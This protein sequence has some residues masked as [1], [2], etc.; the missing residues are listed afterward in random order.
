MSQNLP[1]KY[2]TPGLPEVVDH[3]GAADPQ[4]SPLRKIRRLL[5]GRWWLAIV[6]A[7]G[8]G[9]GL[10][11]AGYRYVTPTYQSVGIIEVKP[12]V[13][14]VMFQ[15]EETSVMPMFDKYVASQVGLMKSPRV[16]D[17]AMEDPRWS[18]LGRGMSPEAKQEFRESL[19]ITSERSSNLIRV[20][21]VD[22]NVEAASD[23]VASVIQAYMKI[24]GERDIKA[25]QER[26]RVLEERRTAL[27]NETNQIGERIERLAREYGSQTLDQMYQFKL[28]EM[29]QFEQALQQTEL[30][31]LSAGL[32]LDP[33]ES[34]DFSAT[35]RPVGPD[36]D[37]MSPRQLAGVDEHMRALIAQKNTLDLQ[38]DMAKLRYSENHPQLRDLREQLALLVSTIETYAQEVRRDGPLGWKPPEASRDDGVMTEAEARK[39]WAKRAQLKILHAAAR[40]RA[41]ALGR[42]DLEITRLRE[43]RESVKERLE[44]TKNRIEQLNVE[45][46]VSGRIEIISSGVGLPAPV[47]G[48]KRKQLVAL[49]GVGGASMA[50]MFVMFL[51]YRDKRLRTFE[52]A[53]LHLQNMRVLGLL[54]MLPENLGDPANAAMAGYSVH[55]IRTMLQLGPDAEANKAFAITSAA[56][57]TGK[58]SLTL[59]LGL[60]FASAGSK[61]L[62]ID[63]DLGGGG[64]TRRL[65]AIVRRRLGQILLQRGLISDSQLR[66]ALDLSREDTRRLGEILIEMGVVAEDDLE[67]ALEFQKSRPVGLLDALGRLGLSECVAPTCM[68][69]LSVLPV[70]RAE[71]ADL[72]RVSPEAIRRVIAQARQQY[73]IVLIDTGPIPGAVETAMAAAGADQTVLVVSRNEQRVAVE[74]AVGLLQ[75][76][77]AGIAG[78]VFNRA[79][80]RD[81]LRSGHLSSMS[82][83]RSL[84]QGSNG[85]DHKRK[86]VRVSVLAG[87]EHFD[88]VTRAVAATS[89]VEEEDSKNSEESRPDL[90]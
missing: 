63:C 40:E 68:E 50:M 69:N 89:A 1:I 51:G 2:T 85:E 71:A 43:Q 19:S 83:S 44:Q 11:Y 29:H 59:A 72:S 16:L 54:P 67:R 25:D 79:D 57:G 56:P 55:H 10:G 60:S 46:S 15:T 27:I 30:E 37:T 24:F 31:L 53:G 4:Q 82:S 61:V 35:T 33:D 76:I 81:V 8:W 7:I 80:A 21:F 52:D 65:Q 5:R 38:V 62:L 78:L 48:G 73:D 70:G 42:Q 6:L 12:Y 90:N 18:R 3:G 64:L 39:L 13:P 28:E 87:Q 23:A 58:T 84:P 26:F 34:I 41:L 20:S 45:S 86:I 17:Q 32:P 22:E 75:T 49:G 14:R 47:N 88:P 66:E 77:G 36:W 74:Q 9:A